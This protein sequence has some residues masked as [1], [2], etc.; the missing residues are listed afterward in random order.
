[1]LLLTS[2]LLQTYKTY[3]LTSHVIA[4]LSHVIAHRSDASFL[5]FRAHVNILFIIIMKILVLIG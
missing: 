2:H 4:H 1:M 3:K 5:V